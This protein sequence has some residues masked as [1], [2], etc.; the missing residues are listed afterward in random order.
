MNY[1]KAWN[2]LKA[3]SGYRKSI[4]MPQYEGETIKELMDDVETRIK[5]EPEEPTDKAKG[6]RRYSDEL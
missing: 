2:T 1:K 6:L 5:R 4:D 3:E